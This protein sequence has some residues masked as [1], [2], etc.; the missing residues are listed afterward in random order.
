[1]IIYRQA[2]KSCKILSSVEIPASFNE[3]LPSDGF[4]R[5]K[6][7]FYLRYFTVPFCFVRVERLC[8]NKSF[9]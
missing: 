2:K 9:L 8:F 6:S 4:F 7:K 1:M 5:S 3:M